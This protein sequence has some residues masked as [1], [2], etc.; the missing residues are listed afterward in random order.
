MLILKILTS[1]NEPQICE[2]VIIPKLGTPHRE[3]CK[4][5]WLLGWRRF[6]LE[7]NVLTAS[8]PEMIRVAFAY[9]GR[10]KDFWICR[11]PKVKSRIWFTLL[12]SENIKS[13]AH[14]GRDLG[15]RSTTVDTASAEIFSVLS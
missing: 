10:I 1:G 13:H 2:W 5:Q 6:S 14:Q 12:P 15:M 3:S 4:I 8:E 9:A 11:S 7:T